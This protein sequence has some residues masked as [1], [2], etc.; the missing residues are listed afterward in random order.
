MR[1]G[2]V[3]LCFLLFGWAAAIAQEAG[4]WS[5]TVDQPGAGSYGVTMTLDGQGGGTTSYPSLACGGT[6]S[7]GPGTYFEQ[8]TSNRAVPGGT[9]GCI[10]GNISVAV[11]GNTMSW[12]WSGSWE[13]QSYTASATLSRV[14]GAAPSAGCDTCGR[15]LSSDVAAG[16]SSSGLLRTYVQQSQ[17][18][19]AN[20]TRREADRCTSDCWYINLANL[21]PNC[22]QFNDAGHRACVNQT[23]AGANGTCQ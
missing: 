4:T 18:K 12:S 19:Y 5:G 7:G 6:L 13:G 2:L 14:G 3:C 15:A 23:I 21:L 11:S 8:I 9:S 16:V 22:E 1:L 17:A 10:D 20:C